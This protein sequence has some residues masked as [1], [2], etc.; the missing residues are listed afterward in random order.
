MTGNRM[1]HYRYTTNIS[2]KGSSENLTALLVIYLFNH[3][4]TCVKYDSIKQKYSA[5]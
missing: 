3:H 5:F 4:N 2:F 1:H